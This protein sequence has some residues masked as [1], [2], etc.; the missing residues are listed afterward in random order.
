[1]RPKKIAHKQPE[2][3]R[4]VFISA[5][6]KSM[7]QNTVRRG[8]ISP[9]LGMLVDV[10]DDCHFVN[11]TNEAAAIYMEGYE[12]VSDSDSSGEGARVLR[13][14]KKNRHKKLENV[15]NVKKSELSERN[16]EDDEELLVIFG[17]PGKY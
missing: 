10:G 9:V 14:R 12:F 16:D 6:N 15:R 11:S 13:W 3:K 17:S 4:N 1:M 5:L 2:G 8:R 7:Q